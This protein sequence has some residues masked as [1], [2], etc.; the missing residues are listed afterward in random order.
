M[1]VAENQAQVSHDKSSSMPV[2]YETTIVIIKQLV[3]RRIYPEN[4]FRFI[5][6][7][8]ARKKLINRSTYAHHAMS[9]NNP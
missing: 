6:V 8:P 5:F 2:P 3:E 9:K 7:F 1:A 4:T